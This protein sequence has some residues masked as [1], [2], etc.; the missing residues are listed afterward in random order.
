[1]IYIKAYKYCHEHRCYTYMYSIGDVKPVM[2]AVFLRCAACTADLSCA[3]KNG[4]GVGSEKARAS[5]ATAST[6]LCAI[7]PQLYNN[8]EGG[9][10]T[11]ELCAIV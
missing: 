3:G 8:I 2:V 7:T 5:C 4:I 11:A 1:M 6:E 10:S 9:A